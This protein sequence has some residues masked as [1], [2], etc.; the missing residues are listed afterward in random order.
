MAHSPDP[1]KK[2]SKTCEKVRKKAIVFVFCLMKVNLSCW[3]CVLFQTFSL[4]LIDH[5]VNS[6]LSP[7][8]DLDYF[9][10]KVSNLDR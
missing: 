1:A 9:R 2:L 6:H 3:R 10:N 7:A 4:V 8:P 5:P